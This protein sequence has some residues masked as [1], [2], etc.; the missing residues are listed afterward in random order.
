MK[1]IEFHFIKQNMRGMDIIFTSITAQSHEPKAI[2]RTASAV[3][4]V[5]N[6]V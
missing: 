3:L 2:K 6:E 5:L 4:P 1:I